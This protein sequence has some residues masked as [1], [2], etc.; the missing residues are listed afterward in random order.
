MNKA[1]RPVV[2]GLAKEMV[3]DIFAWG[4]TTPAKPESN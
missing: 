2:D 4:S 1:G 3:E